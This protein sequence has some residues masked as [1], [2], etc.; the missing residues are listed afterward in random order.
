MKRSSSVEMIR[1]VQQEGLVVTEGGHRLF[2][3]DTVL[4]E[5]PSCLLWSPFE[6]R[7]TVTYILCMYRSRDRRDGITDSVELR[8]NG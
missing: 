1:I 2:E 5:I 6:A 8:R 4:P 3:R 7:H